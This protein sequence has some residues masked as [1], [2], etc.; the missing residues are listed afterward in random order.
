MTTLPVQLSV[1]YLTTSSTHYPDHYT[2]T[3]V[4]TYTTITMQYSQ[5]NRN[6]NLNRKTRVTTRAS[7]SH[8]QNLT[9][10]TQAILQ[11]AGY[12][13][14]LTDSFPNPLILQVP[15]TPSPSQESLNSMRRSQLIELLRSRLPADGQLEA[16]QSHQ[17]L[18]E[19]A[20]TPTPQ[21]PDSD[22]SC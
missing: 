20:E 11:E 18:Q 8:W 14:L 6:S 1:F 5:A 15:V 16:G 17:A 19:A 9:P 22:R 2:H 4:H 21:L 3:H 13:N 7:T 10:D 12:A